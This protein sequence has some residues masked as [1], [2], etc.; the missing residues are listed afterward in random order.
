MDHIL[1]QLSDVLKQNGYTVNYSIQDKVV[2][3]VELM[4]DE[5]GEK[6]MMRY[7]LPDFILLLNVAHN[8]VKPK[9]TEEQKTCDHPIDKRYW[10]KVGGKC[11]ECGRLFFN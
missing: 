1:K 5:N 9:E 3:C 8:V 11:L 7:A 6:K 4:R 2:P 10:G